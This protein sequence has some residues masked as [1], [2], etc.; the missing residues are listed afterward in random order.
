[1][2]EGEWKGGVIKVSAWYSVYNVLPT[3]IFARVPRVFGTAP[4]VSQQPA[5]VSLYQYK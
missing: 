2:K 1:M 3:L 4:I 5:R